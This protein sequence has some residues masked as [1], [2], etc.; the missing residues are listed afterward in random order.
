MSPCWTIRELHRSASH[1]LPMNEMTLNGLNRLERAHLI[2]EHN[3]ETKCFRCRQLFNLR[4]SA[5][6]EMIYLAPEKFSNHWKPKSRT[7]SYCA[8]FKMHGCFFP[9]VQMIFH[10]WIGGP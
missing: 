10:R 3:A 5:Q 2:W 9:F 8:S 7:Q 4:R 1:S 6:H